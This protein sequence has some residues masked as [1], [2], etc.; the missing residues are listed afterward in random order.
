MKGYFAET[1]K[2]T[3]HEDC[4]KTNTIAQKENTFDKINQ[5]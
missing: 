5:R 4:F 2:N 3:Q 1:E